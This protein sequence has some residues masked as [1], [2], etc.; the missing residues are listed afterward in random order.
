MADVENIR[1]I[2]AYTGF[3]FNL[4]ESRL[5]DFTICC[6]GCGENIPA[7]VQTLPDTWIIAECPLCGERRAYLPPDI[8]RGR[9]SFRL[10]RRERRVR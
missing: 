9:V 3:V 5:C 7:P 10:N 1:L 2:F 4:P 8:F 6:K